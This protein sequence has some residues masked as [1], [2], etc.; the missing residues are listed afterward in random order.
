MSEAYRGFCASR[1]GPGPTLGHVWL[2][3]VL[4]ALVALALLG[5]LV[6]AALA[7]AHAPMP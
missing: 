1:G 7:Y 5:S 3:R 2:W 4:V 6:M